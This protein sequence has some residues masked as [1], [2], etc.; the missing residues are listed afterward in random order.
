[1]SPKLITTEDYI[2]SAKKIHGNKYDYSKVN[3]ENNNKKR[4]ILIKVVMD[5]NSVQMNKNFFPEVNL[6]NRQIRFIKVNMIIH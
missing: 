6:S 5:V 3:Y 2:K 4:L 1:M